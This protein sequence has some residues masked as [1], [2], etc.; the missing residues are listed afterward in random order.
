MWS[1]LQLYLCVINKWYTQCTLCSD[2][3]TAVDDKWSENIAMWTSAKASSW[4]LLTI[5]ISAAVL[6]TSVESSAGMY[7]LWYC[8]MF[9]LALFFYPRPS[10][11]VGLL[12]KSISRFLARVGN[13]GC[14]YFCRPICHETVLEAC[15]YEINS[16]SDKFVGLQAYALIQLWW[17]SA[18]Y[19]NV[20]KWNSM[21][22]T[23]KPGA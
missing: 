4:L 19:V 23:I 20:N 8:F 21:T 12:H 10:G 6:L 15:K 17:N 18:Q 3:M 7:S 11:V 2:C 22:L 9:A 14:A 1:V 13:N 16:T 5:V